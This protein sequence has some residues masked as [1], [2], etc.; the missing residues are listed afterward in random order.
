VRLLQLRLIAAVATAATPEA[1][2][3]ETV[4]AAATEP[5]TEAAATPLA[6]AANAAVAPAA[7]A[8]VAAATAA[9]TATE[10]EAV[11]A[12]TA[13]AATTA[14]LATEAALA[15]STTCSL[16]GVC[17][18]VA[19]RRRPRRRRPADS[20]SARPGLVVNVLNLGRR[21]GHS[22]QAATSGPGPGAGQPLACPTS[23]PGHQ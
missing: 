4:A 21:K 16:H 11:T 18:L 22:G 20:S 2:A 10:A 23:W 14:A 13:A 7:T 19:C 1:Q 8:A 12:A 15:M 5:E 6:A 3:T 17:R 9:A